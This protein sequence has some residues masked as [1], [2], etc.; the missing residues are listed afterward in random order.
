M[1]TCPGLTG[2][3]IH[4]HH[5]PF[6]TRSGVVPRQFRRGLQVRGWGFTCVTRRAWHESLAVGVMWRERHT[7]GSI[8]L[9]VHNAY[10]NLLLP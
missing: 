5:R 10:T 2:L 1:E 9:R 6:E 4:S 7:D 3:D 8:Q